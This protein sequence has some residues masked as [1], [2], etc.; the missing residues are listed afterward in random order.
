MLQTVQKSI[1]LKDRVVRGSDFFNPTHLRPTNNKPSSTRKTMLIYHSSQ[2]LKGYQVFTHSSKPKCKFTKHTVWY[3]LYKNDIQIYQVLEFL[4]IFLTQDST[5]PTKKL[6]NLYPIQ[7][8]S[9]H[10]WVDP[11]RI[12][13][14]A[15]CWPAAENP[16]K[17][18]AAEF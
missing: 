9:T 4:E 1:N 7:P 6:N 3:K 12:S 18:A 16:Q 11:R 2:S 13:R 14:S 5:Q 15:E 8:N 17:N 10:P